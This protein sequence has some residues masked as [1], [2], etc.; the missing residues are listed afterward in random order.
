MKLDTSSYYPKSPL[1]DDSSSDE[2]EMIASLFPEEKKTG[3]G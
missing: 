3:H 2:K 1:D